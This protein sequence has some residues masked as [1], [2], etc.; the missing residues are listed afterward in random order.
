MA[1][2]R[3]VWPKGSTVKCLPVMALLVCVC[4][5][6]CVCV[7][8]SV[9]VSVCVCLCVCVCVCL[10]VQFLHWAEGKI[11][12]ICKPEVGDFVIART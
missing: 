7:C 2:R 11:V 4:V 1:S 5:C 3:S 10:S 8:L 6:A 9:C 12:A